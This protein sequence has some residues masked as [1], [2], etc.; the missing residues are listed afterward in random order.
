MA[1]IRCPECGGFLKFRNGFYTCLF[2]ANIYTEFDVDYEVYDNMSE[3]FIDMWNQK[4]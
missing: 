2:C 4:G 3:A 1:D